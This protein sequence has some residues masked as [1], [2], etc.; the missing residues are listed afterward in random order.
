[1]CMCRRPEEDSNR[2]GRCRYNPPLPAAAMA[3]VARMAKLVDAPDLGSGAARRG[4]SSPLP[5]TTAERKLHLKSTPYPAC[6]KSV[7][8]AHFVRSPTPIAGCASR[9]ARS[10][11]HRTG[12]SVSMC[13]S[14]VSCCHRET[15]LRHH[16][17]T[18]SLQHLA[19]LVRPLRHLFS[20]ACPR[21]TT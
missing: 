4:G 14:G 19:S 15:A 12:S 2:H 13:W 3:A 16:A 21:F 18:L 11:C 8:S 6:A 20:S 17:S 1:M 9:S 5:G 10:Y 7:Q